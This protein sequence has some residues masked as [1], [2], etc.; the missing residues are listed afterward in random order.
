[1]AM[2]LRAVTSTL[3]FMLLWDINSATTF[4]GMASASGGRRVQDTQLE[5][6]IQT[7]IDWLRVRALYSD[8]PVLAQYTDELQRVLKPSCK[9]CYDYFEAVAILRSL[10][11]IINQIIQD[12][13]LD[14]HLPVIRRSYVAASWLL[15][16]S[17]LFAWQTSQ[18]RSTVLSTMFR[19][20]YCSS[21][22]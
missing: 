4:D 20:G 7:S 9:R 11:K 16:R 1:M 14:V 2:L 13:K 3:A 12:D 22:S 15:Q 21:S 19:C 18:L 8:Y 5:S 10:G 17:K 6:L